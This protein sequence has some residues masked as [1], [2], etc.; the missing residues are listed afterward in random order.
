MSLFGRWSDLTQFQTVTDVRT[1]FG[2][3]D[4]H[5][6]AFTRTV[7]D[8][9]DDLRVLAAFPRTGLLAGVSQSQLVQALRQFKQLRLDWCGAWHVE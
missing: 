1:H 7:G 4:A 9:R 6:A 8:F 2:V 3:T 5:W